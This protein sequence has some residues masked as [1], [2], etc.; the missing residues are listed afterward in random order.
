MPVKSKKQMR[1][2]YAV[3]SG[4]A[5]K[6]PKGLSK[7]EAKEMLSKTENKSALPEKAPKKPKAKKDK[8]K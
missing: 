5:E 6:K 2:M 7:K 8:K 1:L 4:K 3:A